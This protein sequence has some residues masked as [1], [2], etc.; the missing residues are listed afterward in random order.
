MYPQD[1][2]DKYIDKFNKLENNIYVIEEEVELINGVYEGE[3]EHDNVNVLSISVFTGKKLTGM[4]V[5]NYIV[6]TASLTPWRKNIKIF[7][8]NVDKVYITYETYGD[9]VEA[10]DINNLQ[11]S[12]ISTQLELERHKNDLQVHIINMEVDGGSFV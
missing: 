9:T 4:K 8:N 1:G 3:L 10:E 7:E 2:V 11:K 6:S 5:Q 12:I